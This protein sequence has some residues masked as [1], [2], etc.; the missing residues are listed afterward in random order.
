ML[1]AP[2]AKARSDASDGR[3]AV[4]QD[5]PGRDCNHLDRQG[6]PDRDCI[7]RPDCIH[8]DPEGCLDRAS[9]ADPDAPD[10]YKSAFPA[11][12]SKDA[13]ASPAA[14]EEARQ[15]TADACS[16][17]PPCR[18]AEEPPAAP[19][20]DPLN[21]VSPVD[22]AAAM[23]TLA[24]ARRDAQL[25]DAEAPECSAHSALPDAERP[26]SPSESQ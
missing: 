14:A 12:D 23:A 20:A 7:R 17:S 16:V 22:A 6:H 21:S 18:D 9:A 11:P 1:Q 26:E 2:P 10:L 15:A 5:R 3:A 24:P 8:L 19:V 4:H 13:S 25:A